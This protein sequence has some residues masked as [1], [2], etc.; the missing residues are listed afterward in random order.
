MP[1]VTTV[2]MQQIQRGEKVSIPVAAGSAMKADAQIEKVILS[3]PQQAT[4]HYIAK[5]SL[6][7]MLHY[8]YSTIAKPTAT[9]SSQSHPENKTYDSVF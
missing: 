1:Q 9:I 8:K 4:E 7:S 2:Q 5:K 3:Y 6:R